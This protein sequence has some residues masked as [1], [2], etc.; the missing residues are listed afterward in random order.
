MSTIVME[1][2]CEPLHV[3]LDHVASDALKHCVVQKTL[4]GDSCNSGGGEE[5][6]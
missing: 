6:I 3:H 5:E 2:C 4:Q 1:P